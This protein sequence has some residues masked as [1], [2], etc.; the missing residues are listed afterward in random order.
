MDCKDAVYTPLQGT[1]AVNSGGGIDL[2]YAADFSW[3]ARQ[4]SQT[5][6]QYATRI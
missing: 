1:K 5:G 2:E 4:F 3:A 6:S